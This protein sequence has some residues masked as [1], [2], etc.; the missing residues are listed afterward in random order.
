KAD[1]A[2]LAIST[3]EIEPVPILELDGVRS[4]TVWAV[5]YPGGQ[6]MSTDR[7]ILQRVDNGVVHASASVDS[8]QS[9]GGL[10]VCHDGAWSMIGMLRGFGAT[11]REGRYVRMNDYSVSVAA[12]TINYFFQAR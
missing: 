10:L 5:G 1:L 9:G 12:Q 11:W 7:G 4:E 3:G 6:E 8:G 2:V